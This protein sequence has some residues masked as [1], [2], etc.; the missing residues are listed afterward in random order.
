MMA[1]KYRLLLI[2]VGL[3]LLFDLAIWLITYQVATAPSAEAR[4]Q[5][6][7]KTPTP[8]PSPVE[9]NRIDRKETISLNGP[10]QYQQTGSASVNYAEPGLNTA[11]WP[12]M[13]LPQNWYLAGLNYH[14]T[15]WFRRTFPSGPDWAGRTV[16]LHFSGVDYQADVWLNGHHLGRHE[17]YFQPFTFPIQAYLNHSGDNVLA[18]RVISPYE[19]AETVWPN[20]KTV[21]KGI[22]NHH[23]TR[24]GGDAVSSGQAYNSG[25]IWG[26]IVLTVENALTVDG[27]QLRVDWPAETNDFEQAPLTARAQLTNHADTTATVTARLTLQPANFNGPT[28]ALPPQTV[29]LHRGQTEIVLSDTV[30]EPQLWWPWERGRPNLY[31]A[32]LVL[33]EA[34]QVVAEAKTQ[35]GFRQMA[36]D[37]TGRWRINGRRL[38][39]RGGHYLSS[40]WL[41]QTDVAWFRRDLTLMRQA[42]LNIVRLP[43]HVEPKSFYQQADELGMLVWQDFPLYGGY[44]DRPIFVDQAQAQLADMIALLNN[45]PSLVAWNVHQAPPAA[46]AASRSE[47]ARNRRLDRQLVALA[48]K[49]DPSRYVH[50]ETKANSAYLGWERGHWSDFG[51]PPTA[52]LILAYGAQAL[53]DEPTLQQMLPAAALAYD[54]REAR[55]RWQFHGFQS[56]PAFDVAQIEPGDSLAQ[57]VTDSQAYQAHL[58]QYASESYRRAKGEPVHGLFYGLLIDHWPAISEAVIDYERRPK[59]GYSALQTAMQPILPSI[60]PTP[61]AHLAGRR[62]VYTDTD[63]L[64]FGLWVVNDSLTPY[65]RAELIWE[66]VDSTAHVLL[67]DRRRITMGIDQAIRWHGLRNLALPPGQYTLRLMVQDGQGNG[68]G[69]NSLDF[70]ITD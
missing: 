41:S 43:A 68:L 1:K 7:A 4:A 26:D 59:P 37:Q 23:P 53:P 70:E 48:Q 44:S 30:I 46:T 31:T 24:P 40:Q 29:A 64:H 32:Q 3:F 36:V 2:F 10:W 22:F 20:R 42:N 13:T 50:L 12:S 34:D 56:G 16:R 8:P 66:I 54:S 19:E 52:S 51:R 60:E 49:L 69:Q 63:Q 5:A 67:A 14:G 15:V 18:V 58:I 39:L 38:F 9:L 17:G 21:I 27:L 6:A 11:A 25:G 33:I 35:F 45:H 57:F 47:Q 65:P 61:P 62:W 28:L 55:R